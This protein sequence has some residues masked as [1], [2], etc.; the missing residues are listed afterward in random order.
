MVK[1]ACNS[2]GQNGDC[3]DSCLS[4]TGTGHLTVGK[5][6]GGL[7]IYD[8]W[9]STKFGQIEVLRQ[10]EAELERL[11]REEAMK[12]AEEAL[13]RGEPVPPG[14][15]VNKIRSLTQFFALAFM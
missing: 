12:E 7:M 10:Q 6:Y 8:T 14:T 1:K 3:T 13:A 4:A 11:E 15:L 5:L 2:D 9:K